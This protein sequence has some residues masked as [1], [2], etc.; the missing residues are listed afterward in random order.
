MWSKALIELIK[1]D[2]LGIHSPSKYALGIPQSRKEKRAAKKRN[3]N[4]SKTC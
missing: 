3:K 4:M 2:L 1:V